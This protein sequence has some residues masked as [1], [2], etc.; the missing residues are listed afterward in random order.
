M[1]RRATD[2]QY[3][4]FYTDGSAARQ[5]VMPAAP[6]KNPQRRPRRRKELTVDINPVAVVGT[7]LVAVMLVMMVVG[8]VQVNHQRQQL[9]RLEEYIA[10]LE[11]S[12]EVL[13]QEYEAGYD[14]ED[15]GRMALALG[16]IPQ[17]QAQHVYLELPQVQQQPQLT[18]WQEFFQSLR[19]LLA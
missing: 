1:A 4:Q 16:M 8:L 12:N 13:Q 14:L 10:R 17:E 7:V 2:I 15:I 9:H 18:W 3:I 11:Q 19:Q 6:K 5:P